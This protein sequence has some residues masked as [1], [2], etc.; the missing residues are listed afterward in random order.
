MEKLQQKILDYCAGHGIAAVGFSRPKCPPRAD[1]PVAISVVV[2][3]SRAV[4]EEI[5]D[6]PTHSYFHHY[7]TVNAYLDR[8]LLEIGFLLQGASWGYLPIGASQSIPD[9]AGAGFQGR[10]SHKQAAVAAGLGGLGMN[11]LFL[12]PQYGPAVRLGTLFTDAPLPCEEHPYQT[13]CTGCGCCVRA[14]PAGA[15]R[16]IL[17]QPGD[18]LSPVD[19]PACSEYMKRAFQRIGRGAVCGI[20]MAVCP[21]GKKAKSPV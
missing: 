21:I 5:T 15:L 18:T 8:S 9:A 1:L 7:R 20:C 2:P 16:G 14:C 3:L 13:P 17:W 12:H 4:V 19:A 11:D 10:F 6:C